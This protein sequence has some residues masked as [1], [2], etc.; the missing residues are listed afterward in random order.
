MTGNLQFATNCRSLASLGMTTTEAKRR[1]RTIG[2]MTRKQ[3]VTRSVLGRYG[4]TVKAVNRLT[5]SHGAHRLWSRQ[6]IH[7]GDQCRQSGCPDP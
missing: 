2:R 1:R 3:V 4:R 6:L 7:L 5:R